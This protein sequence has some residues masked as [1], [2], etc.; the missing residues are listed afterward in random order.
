[1]AQALCQQCRQ[2]MTDNYALIGALKLSAKD[3][4]YR[5]DTKVF[6]R[7]TAK[8]AASSEMNSGILIAQEEAGREM[9]YV[10]ITIFRR[11]KN[12]I[13]TN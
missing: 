9:R 2:F 3:W 5:E 1:M 8:P 6:A 7:R 11:R 10:G 4:V 13:R 12:R